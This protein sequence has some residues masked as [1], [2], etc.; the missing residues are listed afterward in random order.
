MEKFMWSVSLIEQLYV[1]LVVLG[2]N[3]RWIDLPFFL[4][5]NKDIVE[6][7]KVV[8]LMAEGLPEDPKLLRV[9]GQ[10]TSL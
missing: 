10:L 5:N 2:R 6:Q 3:V 4:G 1:R 7:K 9:H 8:A